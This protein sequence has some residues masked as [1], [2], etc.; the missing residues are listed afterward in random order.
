M[1]EHNEL[2]KQLRADLDT[3]DPASLTAESAEL[4]AGMKEDIDEVLGADSVP[5]YMTHR[6]QFLAMEF[7]ASHPRLTEFVNHVS[8]ALSNAGL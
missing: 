3:I 6:L 1:S 7:E 8:S 2:L 4:L 5:P